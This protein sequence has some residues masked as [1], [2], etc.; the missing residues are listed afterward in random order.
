MPPSHTQLSA[1][2]IWQSTHLSWERCSCHCAFK[3]S[4]TGDNGLVNVLI[5]CL[6]QQTHPPVAK[7]FPCHWKWQL[8]PQTTIPCSTFLLSPEF[9][10]YFQGVRMISSSSSPSP[11]QSSPQAQGSHYHFFI[12]SIPRKAGKSRS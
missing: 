9:L 1:N 12:S 3:F 5:S 6:E 2:P 4:K 7:A 11:A 10:E 8:P